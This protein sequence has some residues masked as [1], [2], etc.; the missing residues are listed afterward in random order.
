MKWKTLSTEGYPFRQTLYWVKYNDGSIDI[1]QW[2]VTLGRGEFT[3]VGD[4]DEQCCMFT[5]PTDYP[6]KAMAWHEVL[7][8]EGLRD[9]LPEDLNNK[10]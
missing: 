4:W 2:K 10:L 6:K 9:T 3:L 8:P 7:L 1:C 5:P